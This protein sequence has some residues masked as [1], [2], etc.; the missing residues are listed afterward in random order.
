MSVA[1]RLLTLAGVLFLLGI[2]WFNLGP[3]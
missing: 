3:A 2:V 1:H